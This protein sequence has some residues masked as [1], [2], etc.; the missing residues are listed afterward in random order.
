MT[1]EMRR[2]NVGSLEALEEVV[3]SVD[4]SRFSLIKA[5]FVVKPTEH[6]NGFDIIVSHRVADRDTGTPTGTHKSVRVFLP[7]NAHHIF[8]MVSNTLAALLA[9]EVC[10]ALHFNG[11]RVFDPHREL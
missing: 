1:Q 4:L 2:L 5:D 7:E 9:H 8:Q 3:D 10:E 6:D 11:I